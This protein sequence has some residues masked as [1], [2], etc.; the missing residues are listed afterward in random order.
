METPPQRFSQT[1]LSRQMQPVS[2]QKAEHRSPIAARIGLVARAS[3]KDVRRSSGILVF[4]LRSWKRRS[5]QFSLFLES[6]D[7]W[8]AGTVVLRVVDSGEA[9]VA[10]RK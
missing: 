9:C 5:K 3:S 2:C 4:V 10:I 7:C 1:L 6:Q 8:V